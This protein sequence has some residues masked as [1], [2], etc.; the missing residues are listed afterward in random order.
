MSTDMTIAEWLRPY[1]P[2]LAAVVRGLIQLA[3]GAGFTWALT[4]TADQITMAVSAAAMLATLLWSAWQKISAVRAARRAEVAAAKA[5][6]D[7]TMKAGTAMPV[8]VKVTAGNLPNAAI[9]ISTTEIAK[10]PLPPPVDVRPSP[11]PAA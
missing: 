1:L 10:A 7:A 4:V 5:S 2:I 3:A 9:R 6:A 8:T 11:A